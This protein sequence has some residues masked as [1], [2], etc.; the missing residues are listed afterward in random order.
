M[1]DTCPT[2]GCA[3]VRSAA[4]PLPRQ[5]PQLKITPLNDSE[6]AEI[7]WAINRT[8]GHDRE[9]RE[10]L[11]SS[12][13]KLAAAA[14]REEQQPDRDFVRSI[15]SE[16]LRPAGEQLARDCDVSN[17][18]AADVAAALREEPAPPKA[19]F[20]CPHVGGLG[21]P[22]PFCPICEAK[23]GREEPAPQ[24]QPSVFEFNRWHNAA[25]LKD[26]TR[27]QIRER[28]AAG[29]SVQSL[30]DDFYVPEAFVSAIVSWQL[31]GDDNSNTPAAA[32]PEAPAT[33][34]TKP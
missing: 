13:R 25:L 20:M 26:R 16:A 27:R 30:A 1:S 4:A 2:C 33:P 22:F 12:V 7:L 31:F 23:A 28:H 29:E 18:V 24:P 5:E 6:L 8:F 19:R 3:L 11:K 32:T 15:Q 21:P 9:R 14:L 34:E 10:E 17:I